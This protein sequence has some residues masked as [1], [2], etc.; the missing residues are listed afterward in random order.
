MDDN[1]FPGE[2][3]TNSLEPSSVNDAVIIEP[4]ET[5]KADEPEQVSDNEASERDVPETA[6]PQ[7]N[8]PVPA[9]E[10]SD[11]AKDASPAAAEGAPEPIVI[12]EKKTDGDSSQE[13]P[14]LKPKHKEFS[15]RKKK[16]IAIV[17]IAAF[18]IVAI[19]LG[20][21][22]PI[23][24]INRN[25][26]FVGSAEDFLNYDDG[27]Y[28]VLKDDLTVDGDV[29]VGRGYALDLAGH[30]LTVNG[31]LTIDNPGSGESVV[32]TLK[33]GKWISGGNIDADNIVVSSPNGSFRLCS[34][35]VVGTLTTPED[36]PAG[37]LF[38]DSSI[39]SN[40]AI[41]LSAKEIVINDRISFGEGEYASATFTDVASLTVNATISSA[42][43]TFPARGVTLDNSVARINAVGAIDSLVLT[44]GS[45]VVSFG[46]IDT[47]TSVSDDDPATSETLVLLD[48]YTCGS[49]VDIETVALELRDDRLV[50]VTYTDGDG[51]PIFIRRLDTP[52][53]INVNPDTDKLVAAVA[54][55]EGATGYQFSVDGGEWQTAENGAYE[56][57]ITTLLRS[58]TGTHTI[59]ARAVGN[60]SYDNP[61]AL[62]PDGNGENDSCLYLT[63]ESVSCEYLY[64]I[65]L[66]T[67]TGLSVSEN[68][69]G[70]RV[71]TFANVSFA[72]YYIVLV[73]GVDIGKQAATDS[74]TMTVVLS[75]LKVGTNSIRVTAHSENPDIL[76]SD[77]AMTSTVVEGALDA[78]TATAVYDPT[79]GLTTVTVLPAEGALA[80]LVEYTPTDTEGGTAR[81]TLY[82]TETTFNIRGLSA[83][84]QITITALQNGAYTESERVT[85]TRT[86]D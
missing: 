84:S 49:V 9:D 70:E 32:G 51:E 39:V 76:P 28:F 2:D 11:A 22:L 12:D 7:D 79:T 3:K 58:N 86:S 44:G 13:T 77:E 17:C 25:K 65:E 38:F 72:D 40:G 16:R 85:I 46:A 19:V 83:G 27:T 43:E 36:V 14:D 63:G 74:E 73:N 29:T 54:E 52:L 47:A 81:V 60:Y 10:E 71:L 37:K 20:I 35:A 6:A 78:P 15:P 55:V 31:T 41:T 18:L 68:E 69:T 33:S 24:F 80:Y 56:Y 34:P 42:S 4:D 5:P 1:K 53:D 57:D 23:Y 64:Q 62:D 48:N 67:P 30:S 66:A 50:N 45:K 75:G 61:F 8:G 26:I 82:T 59:S 21:T